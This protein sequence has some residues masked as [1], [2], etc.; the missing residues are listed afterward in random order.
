MRTK[1][2]NIKFYGII[3]TMIESS[4]SQGPQHP[5]KENGEHSPHVS[6]D[7]ARVQGSMENI[8]N[9]VASRGAQKLKDLAAKREAQEISPY[10]LDLNFIFQLNE[11]GFPLRRTDMLHETGYQALVL[12]HD[13]LDA[14]GYVDFIHASGERILIEPD[15]LDPRDVLILYPSDLGDEEAKDNKET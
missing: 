2:I 5:D 13:D 9:P 6:L 8:L 11:G 10:D 1:L 14:L 12:T 15:S 7:A 3:F 4:D